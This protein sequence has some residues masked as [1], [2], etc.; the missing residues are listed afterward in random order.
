VCG[1]PVL[2]SLVRSTQGAPAG[3]LNLSVVLAFAGLT[4]IVMLLPGYHIMFRPA[5]KMPVP[6]PARAVGKAAR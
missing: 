3:A 1:L 4:V 5:S 2:E 6:A